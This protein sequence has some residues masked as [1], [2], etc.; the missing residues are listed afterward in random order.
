MFT[1][2]HE[3]RIERVLGRGNRWELGGRDWASWNAAYGPKGA[4]G[5][6]VPLW[7]NETGKINK[8]VAEHYEKYDL[9]RILQKN[10]STIGPK[11]GGKIHVWVGDADDYFLNNAVHRMKRVLEGRSSPKSDAVVLIEMRKPHSSGGWTDREM[12]QKMAERAGLR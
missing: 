2:R 4:D 7:D 8:S 5:F 9:T 12:K 11:L 3:S 10:W 6:P 1:V